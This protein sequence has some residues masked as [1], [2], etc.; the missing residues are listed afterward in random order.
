MAS[1]RGVQLDL[2]QEAP[3]LAFGCPLR[4]GI[5]PGDYLE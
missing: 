1:A 4:L 3:Y 5:E 2:S